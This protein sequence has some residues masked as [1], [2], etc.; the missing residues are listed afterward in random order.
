MSGYKKNNKSDDP[1]SKYLGRYNNLIFLESVFSNER[2]RLVQVILLSN[3]SLKNLIGFF[4]SFPLL[5]IYN[6][7]SFRDISCLPEFL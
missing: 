7:G 6:F 1:S 2:I 5:A 3:N 4:F